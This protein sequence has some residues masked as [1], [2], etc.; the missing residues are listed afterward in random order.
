[1]MITI[2]ILAIYYLMDTMQGAVQEFA[3]L[4]ILALLAIC[5]VY[6]LI[7]LVIELNERF[8]LCSQQEESP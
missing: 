2:A 3:P 8:S 6:S 1:M 7:I 5:F 4:G